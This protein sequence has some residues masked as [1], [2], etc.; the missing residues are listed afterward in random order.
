MNEFF[1]RSQVLSPPRFGVESVSS[2]NSVVEGEC[3]VWT[4]VATDNRMGYIDGEAL[5]T[6]GC[7]CMADVDSDAE[8]GDGGGKIGVGSGEVST[9]TTSSF[10][11]GDESAE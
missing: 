7:S 6:T 10:D 11:V 2:W 5:A 9:S 8:K 1:T 3:S 4:G